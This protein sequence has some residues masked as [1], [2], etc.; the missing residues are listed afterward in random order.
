MAWFWARIDDSQEVS[1]F[2][3]DHK[4]GEGPFETRWDAVSSADRALRADINALRRALS[5]LRREG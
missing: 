3:D 2:E 1:I 5:K 4:T